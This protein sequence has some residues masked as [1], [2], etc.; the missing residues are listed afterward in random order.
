MNSPFNWLDR[1]QFPKLTG[2][3]SGYP[4][5]RCNPSWYIPEVHEC[6][7]PIPG[8]CHCHWFPR[9][10]FSIWII[11]WIIS[12]QHFGDHFFFYREKLLYDLNCS[13]VIHSVT[14]K[15]SP[16]QTQSLKNPVTHKLKSFTTSVTHKLTNGSFVCLI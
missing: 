10:L 6:K 7:I 9:T 16:S 1:N 3:L 13:S 2:H 8:S 14:H 15:Q 5:I 11:I 12:G 4:D